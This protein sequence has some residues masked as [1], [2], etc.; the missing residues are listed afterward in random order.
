MKVLT[1]TLPARGERTSTT[2]FTSVGYLAK[3]C[4]TWRAVRSKMRNPLDKCW[5]CKTPLQDGDEIHLGIREGR[6]GN[7]VL[8]K[9][10]AEKAEE[11]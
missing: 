2:R 8:C 9:G 4:E 1:K 5:W 10:C 11:A 7:V 6:G 3:M